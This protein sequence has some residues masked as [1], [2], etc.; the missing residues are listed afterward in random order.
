MR[1]PARNSLP[2]YIKSSNMT[3]WHFIIG[4]SRNA[5]HDLQA[6]LWMKIE[7]FSFSVT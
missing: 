7:T 6:S 1:N 5:Q 4:L 3:D 2:A